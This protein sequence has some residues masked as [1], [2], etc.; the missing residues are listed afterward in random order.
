MFIGD[1][2]GHTSLTSRLSPGSSWLNLQPFTS[3]P[4]C[5]D[6]ILSWSSSLTQVRNPM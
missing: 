3:P 6:M 4:F 5:I 2:V 1:V